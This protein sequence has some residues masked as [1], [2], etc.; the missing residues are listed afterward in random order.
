MTEENDFESCRMYGIIMLELSENKSVESIFGTYSTFAEQAIYAFICSD[1]RW[2]LYWKS[3]FISRQVST[4]QIFMILFFNLCL[5]YLILLLISSF[6]IR[7]SRKTY[8][9]FWPTNCYRWSFSIIASFLNKNTIVAREWV[10]IT[11][12]VRT[13]QK[14]LFGTGKLHIIVTYARL[15]V[16]SLC[17]KQCTRHNQ[18]WNWRIHV[19][20]WKYRS[21][22]WDW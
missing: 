18:T 16:H 20:L 10:R 4:I 7:P 13:I 8:Y 15:S 11:K 17:R 21:H 14:Q 22:R 19:Y 2:F 9:E 1:V 6:Q 5:L 3:T 12:Q